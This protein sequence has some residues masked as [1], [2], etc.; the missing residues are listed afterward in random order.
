MLRCFTCT[1]ERERIV[2]LARRSTSQSIVITVGGSST[3]STKSAPDTTLTAPRR[4][5]LRSKRSIPLPRDL[6]SNRSVLP[7][8][9]R[10]SHSGHTPA[11]GR[12]KYRKQH[13]LESGWSKQNAMLMDRF[14]VKRRLFSTARKGDGY[15]GDALGSRPSFRALSTPGRC[16]C[17]EIFPLSTPG[18]TWSEIFRP[19]LSLWFRGEAA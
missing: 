5:R 6:I 7:G 18:C 12:E 8:W 4:K 1:L 15:A 11:Q 10:A 9:D 3:S 2:G 16:T 19:R 13:Q 14:V 17:S